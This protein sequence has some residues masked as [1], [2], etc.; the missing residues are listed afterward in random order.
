MAIYIGSKKVKDVYYGGRKVAKIYKGSNLI[1]RSAPKTIT[2]Y[3]F[4]DPAPIV[5]VEDQPAHYLYCEN[6]QPSIGD[7]LYVGNGVDT[8]Y[9]TSSSEVN[10]YDAVTQTIT[11]GFGT[12]ATRD[13]Q[14]DITL[15]IT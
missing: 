7:I 12:T 14:Y 13:A 15:P 1:Y 2:Y 11:T 8:I 4:Y 3:C 6:K 9:F 5:S 10:S